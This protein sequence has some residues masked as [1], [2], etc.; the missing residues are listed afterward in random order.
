MNTQQLQPQAY[1]LYN[2]A[3]TLDE[4]WK[5]MQAQIPVGKKTEF[6]ALLM[7]YHNTLVK[8]LLP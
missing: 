8:E 6:F 2:Q 5:Y 7:T 3:N 1:N 4:A